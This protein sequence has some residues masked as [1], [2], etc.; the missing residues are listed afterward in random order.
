MLAHELLIRLAALLGVLCAVLVLER[1]F[2]RRAQRLSWRCWLADL[3]LV[4]I[5]SLLVRL[6]AP[7]TAVGAALIAEKPGA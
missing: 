5:A 2:P 4:V 6:L 7:A 3:G 1:A